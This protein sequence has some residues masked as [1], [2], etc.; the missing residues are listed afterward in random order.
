V[1]AFFDTSVLIAAFVE[2]HEHHERAL[3]LLE[4]VHE[5]KTEGVVSAHSLLEIHAILTRLPRSPRILPQQAATLVEENLARAFTVVALTTKEY[6]DLVTKLGREGITGGQ[7]YDALHLRCA[8]KAMA[9]R[10]YTFNTRHFEALAPP[11]S[12]VIVAP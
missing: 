3:P 5:G 1:K 2:D 9:D 10:V 7:S 6:L 4:S 11:F 8:E 12:A